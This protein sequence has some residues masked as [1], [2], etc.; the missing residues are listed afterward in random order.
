[1]PVIV[2]VI[3]WWYGCHTFMIN[4]RTQDNTVVE[5][6]CDDEHLVALM[7]AHEWVHVTTTITNGRHHVVA[8]N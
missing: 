3:A 1:M 8:V 7:C 5:L 2:Q 4:C 6:F